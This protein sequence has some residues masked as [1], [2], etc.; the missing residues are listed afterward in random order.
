MLDLLCAWTRLHVDHQCCLRGPAHRQRRREPPIRPWFALRPHALPCLDAYAFLAESAHIDNYSRT[1]GI[2]EALVLSCSGSTHVA[3]YDPHA[4][5][6]AAPNSPPGQ[7]TLLSGSPRTVHRTL[8]PGSL[9]TC[10]LRA[11]GIYGEGE[12]RHLP[13]IVDLMQRGIFCFTFGSLENKCEFVYIDNLVDAHV[14][15]AASL[16]S[17]R[18]A[19]A[20]RA[21]FI[22]DGDPIN[23]FDFFRPLFDGLGFPAP[24]L[25]LPY[26]LVYGTAYVMELIH[27]ALHRLVSFQPLLTRAEVNKTGVTHYFSIERARLELDYVPRVTTAEG[28][29]RVIEYYRARGVHYSSRG[30]VFWLGCTLL[31]IVLAA[32]WLSLRAPA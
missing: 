8:N 31:L 11:A 7:S 3:S 25:R 26:R 18:P 15:A 29:Q 28:M 21:Y 5:L 24:R 1:K 30:A 6:R 4:A 12:E 19:A 13:R 32:I 16:L 22:S 20:G 14:L 10:A 2:A 9:V 17:R 27:R 23:N